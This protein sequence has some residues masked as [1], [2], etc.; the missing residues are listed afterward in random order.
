ML[1]D[2]A[3][4]PKR[5][6]SFFVRCAMCFVAVPA[7]IRAHKCLMCAQPALNNTDTNWFRDRHYGAPLVGVYMTE[8]GQCFDEMNRNVWRLAFNAIV[9]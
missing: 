1:S 3:D 5:A 4:A 2:V 6:S 7:I 9:K 8:D